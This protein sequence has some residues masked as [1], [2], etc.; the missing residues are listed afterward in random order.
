[1]GKYDDEDTLFKDLNI[2]TILA[3]FMV[4]ISLKRLFATLVM[5]LGLEKFIK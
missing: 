1:M 5:I 4:P 3:S 2:N